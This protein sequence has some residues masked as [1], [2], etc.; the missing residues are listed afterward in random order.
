M[1]W[2]LCSLVLSSVAR[3]KA[4][5]SKNGLEA[6][7]HKQ[8]HER[9]GYMDEFRQDSSRSGFEQKSTSAIS[10]EDASSNEVR[11]FHRNIKL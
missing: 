4:F 11:D 5:D 7:Q 10:H 2:L 8:I 9:L 1:N 6:R 3:G